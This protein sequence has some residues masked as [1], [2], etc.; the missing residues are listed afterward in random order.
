MVHSAV[1]A[2]LNIATSILV[3]HNAVIRV[4][5]DLQN[6]CSYVGQEAQVQDIGRFIV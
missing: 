5:Y 2:P 3:H 1:L 4:V 6:K